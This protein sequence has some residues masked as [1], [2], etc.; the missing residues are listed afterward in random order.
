MGRRRLAVE[1]RAVNGRFLELR[2]RLPR[3]LVAL[4]AQV[5]ERASRYFARGQIEITVR[6]P[7][8]AA[9]G[10]LADVDV[11]AGVLYAQGAER[12]REALGLAG[13]L[14]LSTLLR[15]P[16]VAVQREPELEPDQ[17]AAPLLE[18]LE[19]ACRG[20]LAMREREGA[21]LE[22]ELR[23]RLGTLETLVTQIA[24]R[25]EE[26]FRGVRERLEKRLAALAP[27]IEVDPARIAQEVVLYADRMDVTEEIVRLRSHLA[28]FGETLEAEAPVGRKLE[29][30]L[31]ELGREANT[32]GSK[33]ADAPL[34]QLVVEL[35][36]E[37]EK[38]REQVLNVE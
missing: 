12:L 34:A 20:A 9:G 15:L 8:A 22:A 32:I 10:A 27:E 16:G 19:R 14:E 26:V 33:G 35:K 36:T 11:E 7:G 31:Q 28:Q 1:L 25:A 24:G 17:V 30:L 3:E 5:R 13:A 38:L 6:S 29:F 21:E 37:L 23:M 18:A 2:V 4:E